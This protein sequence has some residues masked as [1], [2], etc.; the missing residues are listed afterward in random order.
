MQQMFF[1]LDARE[2]ID[3]CENL[4]FA[5]AGIAA[6]SLILAIFFF[7]RFDIPGIYAVMTGKQRKRTIQ[8]MEERNHETGKLRYQYPGAQTGKRSR[9]ERP[10]A[11]AGTVTPPPQPPKPAASAAPGPA[12]VTPVRSPRPSPSERPE[13]EVLSVDAPETMLLTEDTPETVILRKETGKTEELEPTMLL[14][15]SQMVFDFRI[16]EETIE[17][18]TSE[19]I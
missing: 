17:I 19:L 18:H 12:P 2:A 4:F 1:G 6:V 14:K 10:K 5:F 3:L 8:Q 9:T 7:I 16:T 11:P 15:P 13:T